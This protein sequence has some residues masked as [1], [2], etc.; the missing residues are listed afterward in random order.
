M[1]G[2][3]RQSRLAVI[4]LAIAAPAMAGDALLPADRAI[5]EVVDHYVY[6]RLAAK[7]VKPAAQADDAT[8]VR[9]LTL[10]LDGRIPTEAEV[11]SFVESTD[12]DKR[13]KLVDGLMAGPGFVRH[14]VDTFDAMLMAG[15]RGNLREFLVKAFGENRSWDRVFRELLVGDE[16][17][18]GRK[19]SAAFLKARVKDLDQL[20][21]DVSSV[22]FGVNVSCA[23]CHDHPTVKDWKQDHY[24][25]MKSFIGRT[26]DVG[27]LVAER[28]YGLVKFKTV[29][30]EER[31]ARFMFLTGK[32]VDVPGAEE[33]SK[34]QREA[35]KR[36]REAL[37]KKKG[38]QP[39][40]PAAPKVSAR[41]K[42]VEVALAPDQR[43]FFA[44]A[45]VNRLW[46]QF[47]GAGLVMPLDQMHAENPPSHPELLAWLARDTAEHRYDLRR[48]IRGLVLSHAYSRS[49]AW[50]GPEAPSPRLFAAAAVR[51]LTP[52][53]L[54]TSMWVATTDPAQL[55]NADAR[56]PAIESLAS[57][58]RSL[59]SAIARPGEE[60]QIGAGEALLMSNSDRLKDLLA[61]GGDRLVGRLIKVADPRERIDLAV[62]TVL[63]RPATD[64]ELATLGELFQGHKDPSPET[65]RHLVWALL[66][67]AEFRFNH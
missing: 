33:P 34:E 56:D 10:D 32:V 6:A 18:A 50:E 21:S 53:Q 30:G 17:P 54:A 2:I 11:R 16:S 1:M 47:F 39:P 12:P 66:T 51:P 31:K 13:T 63:S 40:A 9:R 58:A 37:R 27:G 20:T 59:A 7:G 8:I 42:L 41:A 65:C 62:R 60:Y 5:P 22:F 26:Y 57:R 24:Y 45:I 25:G 49:S 14:Q 64:D 61:D 19:G 43:E 3:F 23:K 4:A 67:C 15:T 52:I 38:S 36:Q 29:D 46:D 55:D 35:E 44:R 48:L 28:D